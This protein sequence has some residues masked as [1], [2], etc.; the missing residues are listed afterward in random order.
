MIMDIIR[1]R[2]GLPEQEFPPYSSGFKNR[3]VHFIIQ[4]NFKGDLLGIIPLFG[5]KTYRGK[6]KEVLGKPLWI[7]VLGRSSNILPIPLLDN[8][9]NLFG[10]FTQDLERAAQCKEAN[11]IFLRKI[12]DSLPHVQEVQ[13]VLAFMEQE[14][15]WGKALDNLKGLTGNHRLGFQVGK[16]LVHDHPEVQEYWAKHTEQE[17]DFVLGICCVT[18]EQTRIPTK[19]PEPFSWG[20]KLV[21]AN[22]KSF[23]S[24]GQRGATSSCMG[25]E[26]TRFFYE[27]FEYLSR[28]SE[29]HSNLS[30]ALFKTKKTEKREPRQDAFFWVAGEANPEVSNLQPLIDGDLD[31]LPMFQDENNQEDTQKEASQVKKVI[32]KPHRASIP[33]ETKRFCLLLT[34]QN[35]GRT[36]IRGWYKE[37]FQKIKNNLRQ[38][39]EDQVVGLPFEGEFRALSFKDYLR[40]LSQITSNGLVELSAAKQMRMQRSLFQR[41]L[42]RRAYSHFPRDLLQRVVRR[43]LREERIWVAQRLGL[44]SSKYYTWRIRRARFSLMKI[45]LLDAGYGP[46]AEGG[47]KMSLQVIDPN[48]HNVA[49]LLGRLFTVLH[50]IQRAAIDTEKGLT[51]YLDEACRNPRKVFELLVRKSEKSHI[52]KLRRDNRGL[53][54]MFLQRKKEIDILLQP[55]FDDENGFMSPFPR[56]FSL[57]DR[58]LFLLGRSH[59]EVEEV[60]INR[61]MKGLNDEIRT[62]EK[63]KGSQT[64]RA[65]KDAIQAKIN[66]KKAAKREK[67]WSSPLLANLSSIY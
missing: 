47:R 44:T 63:E 57:D 39:R 65:G 32:E 48:N 50:N 4:L 43:F 51:K 62:L 16:E 3:A 15:I 10:M 59:Q 42:F 52:P 28:H 5:L 37:D 19:H 66:E 7:P 36:S 6:L 26:A 14:K 61:E 33:D 31:K 35:Q 30:E 54:E 55:T 9:K 58:C 22:A 45:G 18:K 60:R 27:G 23:V 41:A 64:D 21:S 46:E 24:Y 8:A 38:W 29:H 40:A 13:A 2:Q 49:Y 34:K 17:E 53:C 1:F 11:L 20:G 12:A 56:S 67:T 25:Q